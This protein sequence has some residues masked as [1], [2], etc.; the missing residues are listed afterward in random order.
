LI[1]TST[2]RLLFVCLLLVLA[3]SLFSKDTVDGSPGP[4][5][6]VEPQTVSA[7]LYQTFNVSIVVAD[8]Q[9]LYGFEIT[10][11][12]D[13]T[14]LKIVKADHRIG[15]EDYPGGI[16]HKPVIIPRDNVS[17]DHG[18][19]LVAAACVNPA[20]SFNGTGTVAVLTFN[21]TNVG[22]CTLFLD[23]ELASDA[24]QGQA[25]PI[26]HQTVNG[27]FGRQPTQELDWK[28]LVVPCAVIV[29]V[30]VLIVVFYF[31]KKRR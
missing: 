19:Y 2:S 15:V 28:A 21:V 27:Y 23:V 29:V 7:D 6:K 10:L 14:I 26:D 17:Q 20:G 11:N 8:I 24:R 3:F 18:L 5:A 31:R 1:P 12:W 22:T 4:V 9:G 16:L 13:P 25:Q 30:L